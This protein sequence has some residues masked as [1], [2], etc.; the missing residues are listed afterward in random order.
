MDVLA[1]CCRSGFVVTSEGS[2]RRSSETENL[3]FPLGEQDNRSERQKDVTECDIT[4][5]SRWFENGAC[6]M[7][8]CFVRP[9]TEVAGGLI[10][11]D[12]Q[13][14]MHMFGTR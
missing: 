2:R 9:T 8:I 5:P 11:C 1:G 14:F 6:T 3:G 12:S 13:C 4:Y 10:G 7:A